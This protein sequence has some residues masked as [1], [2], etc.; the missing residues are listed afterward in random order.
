[1]AQPS[2]TVIYAALTGNA[3]VAASKFAAAG[4]TG[5]GAMLSEAIRSVIDTA[6]QALLLL[7]TRRASKPPTPEHPFGYGLQ[8]YFWT[9]IVAEL[10]FAIGA[11]LSIFEGIARI[12]EPRPVEHVYVNYVVLGVGLVFEGGVWWMALNKFRKAKGRRGWLEAV[13]LSK[14]PTLFTVLFEDTAALLGLLIAFVGIALSKYLDLPILDG[15][16]SLLIGLTLAMTAG[17]LAYECQS[18]LTGESVAPEIRADIRRLATA[19]PEV[20]RVNE[21]LTMHF[22]PCDVLVALSLE[23]DE[24]I[25]AAEIGEAVTSLEQRIKAAHPEVTRIFIEAQSFE[26]HHRAKP[27]YSEARSC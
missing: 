1:M 6:D 22:G 10:I 21:L 24:T 8:L 19:E 4:Y 7:G 23:F 15:I 12:I 9:F 26:A 17:L 16:A 13:Q 11:G 3:A 2:N 5:S 20:E 27:S 18:L 14:D 25:S